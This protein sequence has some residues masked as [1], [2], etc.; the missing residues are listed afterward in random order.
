M[1]LGL[2]LI[3][4]LVVVLGFV[5]P[6]RKWVTIAI[7]LVMW[8]LF[9]FNISNADYAD[10]ITIYNGIGSGY[11]WALTKY[12]EGY[13]LLCIL[14]YR[15]LHLDYAH[16]M[17]LVAF[18]CTTMLSFVVKLY[19]NN[20]KQNLVYSLFMVFMY[21]YMI[22][23]YRS[24][25]A[26]LFVLIGIYI[27]L[28]QD[29]VKSYIGF[30][31][32]VLIGFMFHRSVILYLPFMVAK[33]KTMK[34]IMVYTPIIAILVILPR[35]HL[36]GNIVAEFVPTYKITNWLY[37]SGTR[38]FVGILLL[39]GVRVLL[40]IMESY[41]Y[42]NRIVDDSNGEEANKIDL[43]RKMTLISLAFLSLEVFNKNFE[44]LFRVPLMLAFFLLAS[45]TSKERI[46]LKRLPI[47][48]A[49]YA[50][51]MVLYFAAFAVSFTEWFSGCLIPIFSY[52][53]LFSGF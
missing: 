4:I 30:I 22:C 43:I 8:I 5:F 29:G 28:N 38:S 36:F 12:E 46:S 47:R 6:S 42:G 3:T 48:Y 35:F 45:Y 20:K 37:S 16:F 24:Y 50:G 11:D 1:S 27:L 18:L 9:A 53:S 17:I 40:V 19:T 52:N 41:F 2:I 49:Y 31:L 13:I 14:G 26:F 15:V 39:I 10:Y 7:L 25:I 34:D 33:K 23:Q 44:R 21:W 51:Y 32:F